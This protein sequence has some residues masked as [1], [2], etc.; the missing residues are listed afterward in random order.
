MIAA[1]ERDAAKE[2]QDVEAHKKLMKNEA[3]EV[4]EAVKK[5]AE[6]DEDRWLRKQH[7]K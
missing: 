7:E 4:A 5:A 2:K 3:S 1:R 6:D